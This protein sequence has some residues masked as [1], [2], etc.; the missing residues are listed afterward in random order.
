[1]EPIDT[2]GIGHEHDIIL[3]SRRFVEL[4]IPD[5]LV[6]LKHL[7]YFVLDVL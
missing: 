4:A 2:L 6:V 1:M 7:Q 5:F 3:D